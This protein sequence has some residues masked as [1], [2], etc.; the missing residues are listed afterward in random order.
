M[1]VIPGPFEEATSNPPTRVQG[2]L[3]ACICRKFAGGS[4]FGRPLLMTQIN[5][6][7]VEQ[8]E[9][10]SQVGSRDWHP[11]RKAVPKT[12][13]L[14]YARRTVSREGWHAQRRIA[15]LRDPYAARALERQCH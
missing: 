8:K 12:G 13:Q 5:S 4:T 15:R 7:N 6:L 2:A 11:T 1:I 10:K 14:P 3:S 9:Y